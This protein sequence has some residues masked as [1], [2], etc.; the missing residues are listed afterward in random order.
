MAREY[1]ILGI[2]MIVGIPGWPALLALYCLGLK[3]SQIDISVFIYLWVFFSGIFSALTALVGVFGPFAF[4]N[5]T[6]TLS[7]FWLRSLDALENVRGSRFVIRAIAVG[8]I[9][10][11]LW[12]VVDLRREF[13]PTDLPPLSNSSSSIRILDLRPAGKRWG[14]QTDLRTVRLG[15]N[16]AF[17]ALSYEWEIRTNHILFWSEASVSG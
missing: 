2:D 17:E 5:A 16:P 14:I 12:Y 4:L 15:D 13:T 10:F 8:T 7:Y 9:L 11:S 1:F 6:V 3:H